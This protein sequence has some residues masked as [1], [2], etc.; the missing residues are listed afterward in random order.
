MTRRR[1]RSD[2]SGESKKAASPLADRW[3]GALR[4]NPIVA[5]MIVVVTVGGAVIGFW[6]RVLDVY[7]RHVDPP[8]PVLVSVAA[9]NISAGQD[10]LIT[11]QPMNCRWDGSGDDVRTFSS[12]GAA[13][14]NRAVPL[15]FVLANAA[16]QD[17]V[18]TGVEFDISS[19][20]GVAGGEPG[21]IVPNHTY[22][23][24]L[25]YDDGKQF[26]S[27]NPP[28]RIPSKGTGSFTIAFQ[29]KGEGTG[30]CWIMKA[31]FKTNLGAAGSEEFSLIMSRFARW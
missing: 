12:S 28:Y 24:E 2:Q 13:K 30:L 3:L 6:D 18:V 19:V 20:G 14:E 15:D 5:A 17:A 10:G 21:I 16:D 23:I 11:E 29:P 1:S 8:V 7:H 9:L 25:E 22:L 4:N 27:L 31:L 26:F